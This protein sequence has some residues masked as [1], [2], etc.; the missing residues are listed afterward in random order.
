MMYPEPIRTADWH[1]QD[2]LLA[3]EALV[4]YTRRWPDK[5]RCEY[6]ELLIEEIAMDQGALPSELLLQVDDH[7]R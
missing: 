4:F 7:F 5:E 1:L 3:L 6:A 2:W